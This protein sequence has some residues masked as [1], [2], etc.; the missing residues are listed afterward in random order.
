MVKS[1]IQLVQRK[2]SGDPL[3]AAYDIKVGGFSLKSGRH[4][5]NLPVSIL[6]Q[7]QIGSMIMIQTKKVE[8]KN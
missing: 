7:D 8:E 1:W 5:N 4:L 2:G 3:N 6:G